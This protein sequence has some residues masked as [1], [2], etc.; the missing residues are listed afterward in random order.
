MANRY[1]T[2]IASVDRSIF[3]A[4][5]FRL[6][7]HFPE[8]RHQ[9]KCNRLLDTIDASHTDRSLIYSTHCCPRFPVRDSLAITIHLI[10]GICNEFKSN[11]ILRFTIR[12]FS[13]K[14]NSIE[15]KNKIKREDQRG[16]AIGRTVRKSKFNGCVGNSKSY[17]LFQS[18]I[19]VNHLPCFISS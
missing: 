11:S 15:E 7:S 12:N 19:I 13:I 8:H 10:D 4:L 3:V 16:S 5:F 1:T 17:S 14:R 2:L 18:L 6:F 9:P